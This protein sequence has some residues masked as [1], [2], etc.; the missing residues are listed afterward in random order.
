MPGTQEALPLCLLPLPPL[1]GSCRWNILGVVC[2]QP[3]HQPQKSLS[4]DLGE[5]GWRGKKQTWR[6]PAV[7]EAAVTCVLL[8][9]LSLDVSLP[10]PSGQALLGL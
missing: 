8:V 3:P 5:R 9:A 10:S 6:G 2:T 7:Q 1:P 4:L